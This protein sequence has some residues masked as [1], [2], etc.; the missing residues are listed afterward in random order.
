VKARLALS[1]R[2][3]WGLYGRLGRRLTAGNAKMQRQLDAVQWQVEHFE[4]VPVLAGACLR[5]VRPVWPSLVVTSDYGSIDPAVQN[6]LLAA[7]AAGL[8]AALI[9]LPLWNPWRVRRALHFPWR[10]TCCAV[11][12]LAQLT[13]RDGMVRAVGI[14][15]YLA[16]LD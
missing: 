10:V 14:L 8:G 4:E 1:Y 13:G 6:L 2:L 16:P 9:T 11:V 15:P 3:A 7:R 5:G 12:P